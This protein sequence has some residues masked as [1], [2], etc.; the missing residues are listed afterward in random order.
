MANYSN[1]VNGSRY[2]RYLLKERLFK[3]NIYNNICFMCNQVPEWNSKKLTL[4]I[5]HINGI[6]NDNRIENLRVLCPNCHSQTS[7]YA[8]KNNEKRRKNNICT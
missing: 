2:P 5:D 1:L 8:G 3:E 6:S 4:Q 7:T